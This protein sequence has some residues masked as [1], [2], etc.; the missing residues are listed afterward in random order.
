MDWVEKIIG[1]ITTFVEFP[2][3]L[4]DHASST[5]FAAVSL[6]VACYNL[7]CS[8]FIP[9]DSGVAKRAAEQILVIREVSVIDHA[10]LD[11]LT[12]ESEE[13]KSLMS[14]LE[15]RIDET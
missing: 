13:L 6:I 1:A 10:M 8:G 3:N 9:I 12:A 4:E 5:W 14:S 11:K 2:Y 7:L 15:K